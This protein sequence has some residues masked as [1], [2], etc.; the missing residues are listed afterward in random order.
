MF[1]ELGD[2]FELKAYLTI[3]MLAAL[4]SLSDFLLVVYS[5]LW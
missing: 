3:N 2:N 5:E 1:A 4:L